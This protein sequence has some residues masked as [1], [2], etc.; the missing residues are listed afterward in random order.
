MPTLVL[1]LFRFARLL[2]SGQ[3]AIAVD[4]GLVG[5]CGAAV[6]FWEVLASS[7]CPQQDPWPAER[8]FS[9]GITLLP[10]ALRQDG[11]A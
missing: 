7:E 9:L 1:F 4:H 8:A 11:L 3:A 10:D 6:C 2:F 5:R